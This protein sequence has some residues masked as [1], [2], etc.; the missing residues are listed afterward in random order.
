VHRAIGEVSELQEVERAVD[1]FVAMV[2]FFKPTVVSV[3]AH[4]D[5]SPECQRERVGQPRALREVGHAG[6]AQLG[7]CSQNLDRAAGG[8]E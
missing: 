3:G 4:L 7:L 6:A 1:R 2:A 8:G 5:Q